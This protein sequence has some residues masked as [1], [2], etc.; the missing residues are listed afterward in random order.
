MTVSERQVADPVTC[1]TAIIREIGDYHCT[2]DRHAGNADRRP[3][4]RLE[5]RMKNLTA[6]LARFFQARFRVY[7]PERRYMRG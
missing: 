3:Q 6:V 7:H 1:V 5:K 4:K 2:L